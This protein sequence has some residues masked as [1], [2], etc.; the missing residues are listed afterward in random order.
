MKTDIHSIDLIIPCYNPPQGWYRDVVNNYGKLCELN[1]GIVFSL[2]IVTDGSTKGYDEQTISHIKSSIPSF[3][4]IDYQPNR[5]KGYAL[6]TAVARCKNDH[7]IYTDYDFPYTWESFGKVIAT[8]NAGA[9]VVVAVR[10]KDYQRSLPAFRKILSYTSHLINKI[11]LRLEITDTQGGLKA[12]NAK[13]REIFLSTTID[14][15]LFDTQ[16]V[17][18]ATHQRGV[19]VARVPTRIR[20][21]IHMSAMGFS[22]M[23]REMKNIWVILRNK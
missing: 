1:P 16:F 18:K 2:L 6:R 14:T 10:D 4:L 3:T 15:F 9:D 22:V 8:L 13:G 19:S 12:F 11:V 5:G 21:G 23:R 7:I 17:Y 20:D